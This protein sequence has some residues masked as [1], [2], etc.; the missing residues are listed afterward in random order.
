LIL[1]AALFVKRICKERG[2]LVRE[3]QHANQVIPLTEVGPL[4]SGVE[5]NRL[6]LYQDGKVQLLEE[7]RDFIQSLHGDHFK[8]KKRFFETRSEF[9]TNS[10]FATIKQIFL[11]PYSGPTS[12]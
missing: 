12:T 8:A 6:A 11:H 2:I 3:A 4:Q 1:Y 5:F 7:T 9:I 10:F